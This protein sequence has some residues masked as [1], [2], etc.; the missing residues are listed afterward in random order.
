MT[1]HPKPSLHIVLIYSSYI[2]YLLWIKCKKSWNLWDRDKHMEEVEVDLNKR[3]DRKVK[4][5]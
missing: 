2:Y 4:E 5:M 3:L 1:D